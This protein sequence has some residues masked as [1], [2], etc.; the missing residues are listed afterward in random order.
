MGC[1][2]GLMDQAFAYIE[3]NK[4]V[5]TEKS[6]PYEAYVSNLLA[7]LMF[8]QGVTYISILH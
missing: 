3:A 6:Y 8:K 1:D 5:D 4:G 2:G 7:F